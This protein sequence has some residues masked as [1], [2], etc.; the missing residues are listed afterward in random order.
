MLVCV[1]GKYASI[2]D[3][4]KHPEGVSPWRMASAI[5]DVAITRRR[6]FTGG[7]DI[8]SFYASRL[9][10][11]PGV[12]ASAAALAGESDGLPLRV[13]SPVRLLRDAN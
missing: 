2:K 11:K 5:T 12:A 9:Q 3:I 6:L 4:E 7:V 8:N 1:C 10:G 13:N